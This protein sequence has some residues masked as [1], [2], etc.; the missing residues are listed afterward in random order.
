MTWRRVARPV[1]LGGCEEQ[2]SL[3]GRLLY[4][5]PLHLTAAGLSWL[6]HLVLPAAW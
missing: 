3:L 4:N 1:P 5:K 2:A 6:L